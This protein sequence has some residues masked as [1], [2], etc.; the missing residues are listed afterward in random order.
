MPLV[1]W[2][3]ARWKRIAIA[4]VGLGYIA[5]V[6]FAVVTHQPL[7]DTGGTTITAKRYVPAHQ[8]CNGSGCFEVAADWQ[9]DVL[10]GRRANT[11]DV[12]EQTY[13]EYRVGDTYNQ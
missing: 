11:I 13:D 12:T 7:A 1:S 2:P 4:V 10:T 8:D 9:F 3:S 5:A 6:I